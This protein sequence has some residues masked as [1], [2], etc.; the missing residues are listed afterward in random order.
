MLIGIYRLRSLLKKKI[1]VYCNFIW[2][3]LFQNLF[4]AG[5][6]CVFQ[7]LLS[8]H[9]QVVKKDITVLITNSR[10][11]YYTNIWLVQDQWY[12]MR[13]RTTKPEMCSFRTKILNII[14]YVTFVDPILLHVIDVT[15]D[16]TIQ[17]C[18]VFS[19]WSTVHRAS[20]TS[21]DLF[22]NYFWQ[23]S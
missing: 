18:S 8:D 9:K 5:F 11:I 19:M 2:K 23:T 3:L 21:L 15:R 6:L 12:A 16:L 17:T 4:Q 1:I 13:A 14:C 22:N 10:F 7:C 20:P